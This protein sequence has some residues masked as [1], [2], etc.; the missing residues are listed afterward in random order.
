MGEM[1]EMGDASTHP[2]IG[3]PTQFLTVRYSRNT[4]SKP[5]D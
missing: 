3:N 4:G 1:G 5:N 2:C